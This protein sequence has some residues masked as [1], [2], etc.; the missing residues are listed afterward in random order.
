[1]N[2]SLLKK[3]IN[4]LKIDKKNKGKPKRQPPSCALKIITFE[5]IGS[6]RKTKKSNLTE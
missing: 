5:P 2:R 6:L 1:M 3:P 4:I